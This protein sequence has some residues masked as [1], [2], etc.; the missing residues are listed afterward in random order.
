MNNSNKKKA[1]KQNND[2]KLI[3]A[4]ISEKRKEFYRAWHRDVEEKA[5]ALGISKEEPEFR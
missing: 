4:Q 5:Q 3:S 2:N 1:K